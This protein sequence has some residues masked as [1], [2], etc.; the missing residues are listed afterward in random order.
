MRGFITALQFLTIIKIW[1]ETTWT[2]A[3]FTKSVPYFPL[4]G[5]VIGLV[6]AG[7]YELAYGWLP[8][9]I[10]ATMLVISSIVLT[11]GLHCDGF[12]D[13]I[14][15]LF[16]GRSTDRMLE[17][18]KDSRVGANGVV[19]FVCL[20]LLKWSIFFEASNVVLSQLLFAAPIAGRLAMVSVILVFPYARPQGIGK[21]FADF[22]SV[23]LYG[24]SLCSG[25]FMFI[26]LDWFVGLAALIGIIL[27]LL[28]ARFACGRLG[29][30]TGDIYGAV[31]ELTE[32]SLYAV[33]LVLCLININ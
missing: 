14:D 4:V 11:G 18:M 32:L 28:F 27:G 22:S 7:F 16:S 8:A 25:L 17:I 21:A 20:T 10:L 9:S 31:T 13:S 15:G 23:K 6:L 3:N 19:A 26:M 24:L 29:G 12:M 5:A 1:P 33:G 30:V 2:P